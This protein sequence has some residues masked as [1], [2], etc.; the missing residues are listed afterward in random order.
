[1]IHTFCFVVGV[2]FAFFLLGLGF[3]AVG[4]F[5]K[6][7]QVLFARIGGVIVLLFGIYQLGFLGTSRFLGQEKRL[8]LKLNV[9]AMSPAD[10]PAHGICVQLCLDA[11]RRARSCQRADYGCFRLHAGSGN[12]TDRR[13]YPRVRQLL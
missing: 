10:S 5:F 9:L 12:G 11:L 7:R 6:D 8:P 3:S 4:T 2:S 1:M 13:I